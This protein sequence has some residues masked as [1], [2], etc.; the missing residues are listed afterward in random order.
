M[1]F[2]EPILHV[3]MDAFFV[4]VER[5]RDPSLRGRPVVV[6][7]GGPRGVVASAS[8]EARAFG[9]R[10]AMPMGAARRRC[11]GLVVVPPDH[12][13]YGRTSE[14]VFAI[15]R[16]LTPFVEGLSVDEAF[17]DVSGLR[18][19]FPSPWTIAE[20]LRDRIRR[21]LG[22]PAS[23]GIAASKFVAK[24]A[25]EA[26]KPDGIRQVPL[27]EQE[28]FLHALPVRA[29]W[30]VGAATQ[31]ALER[32]GVETV[33]DLAAVPSRSLARAVGDAQ[34]VHL[35][36]LA[37]GRDAR[38][39]VPDS[40]TKSISVE[41]TFDED[42]AARP[43][44]ETVLLREAE[45]VSARV[46]RAGLTAHTVTLK[47]RYGDFTTVTRSSS[48]AH[49]ID[50]ATE[51]FRTARALLDRVSLEGRTVRLLGIALGGLEPAGVPRQLTVENDERWRR[52]EQAVDAAGERFGDGA[53]VRA[54]LADRPGDDAHP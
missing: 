9:V 44:M 27:D 5:L 31:A 43:A 37:A 52:I 11:P 22:L 28:A 35:L 14:R 7:G 21:D 48:S 33:G 36:E 51:V 10:S 23:V 17:L 3:D 41:H 6:G 4:E 46:R 34:A 12:G 13:A 47:L 26:A 1:A 25:S 39:V 49:P 50:G 15:F 53:I 32:L 8:Y 40:E 2:R 16:E 45:R 54:R 20:G 18:L 24:L 29:L 19:H 30:G 38:P 42:L